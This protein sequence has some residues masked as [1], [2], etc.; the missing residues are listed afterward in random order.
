MIFPGQLLT[1]WLYPQPTDM[2]KSFT[3][4]S[5]LVKVQMAENPLSGHL[6][7]FINR[8]KTHLKILYFSR[9]GYC[10]WSKRLVEGQFH[11]PAS[12][13]IKRSLTWTDL[14]FLIEGI[15]MQNVRYRKR[16]NV[17]LFPIISN[18]AVSQDDRIHA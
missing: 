8:R 17:E 6:F 10:I 13:S 5:G 7:V 9:G 4:L 12:E 15:D 3:G 14:Q 2:R 11:F 18:R 16:K 1:V